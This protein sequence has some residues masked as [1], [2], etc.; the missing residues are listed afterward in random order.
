MNCKINSLSSPIPCKLYTKKPRLRRTNTILFSFSSSEKQQKTISTSTSIEAYT[1]SFKTEK[2]CKLGISRY[3]DFEYD[4][5]GGIGTGVGA[6]DTKNDPA[7]NDLPVSFDLETLYI[8]P[9]T[10]STTKF[11]GLP[12]P[13]FL[14][15]DIVPEAFQ[16]NINQESGKVDLEFKAK[17]LFS[18]AS[19]YKAPPLMVKTVLT[20]EETNGT[21]RRGRGKRLDKEGKCRLVGVATVDPIDDIFMN[22][23]LG[24]PTECLAELNAVISIS[25]SS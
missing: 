17:F 3:P 15:I 22:S 11:L 23:F 8:P 2:G 7:N 14:K 12:L 21:M 25:S 9:L 6:K 4:A 24:L 1:V 19:L 18:A 16:G 10:S 5:E 13:P 20:S